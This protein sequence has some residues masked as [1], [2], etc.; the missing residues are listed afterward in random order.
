MQEIAIYPERRDNTIKVFFVITNGE[1]SSVIV[2]NRTV[3]LE[4]GYQFY[5]RDYVAEQ[6]DKCEF[7]ADG[8][9][10]K[11]VVK[12]GE[13]LTLPTEGEEKQREIEELERKLRELRGEE[14]PTENAE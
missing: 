6:I 14:E 1:V 3:P 4:Q 5:V 13:E 8:F 11:L 2:G 9:T 7:I 10:P 12:E